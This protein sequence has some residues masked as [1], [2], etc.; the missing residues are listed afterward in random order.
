MAFRMQIKRLAMFLSCMLAMPSLSSPVGRQA[1]LSQRLRGVVEVSKEGVRL[2]AL[3]NIGDAPDDV[4]WLGPSKLVLAGVAG[5][6]ELNERLSQ[7]ILRLRSSRETRHV[8]NRG[9]WQSAKDLHRQGFSELVDLKGK[10]EPLALA[11]F[12]RGTVT[13]PQDAQGPP[14]FVIADLWANVLGPG[15]SNVWHSHCKSEQCRSGRSGSSPGISGVYYVSVGN[16]GPAQLQLRDDDGFGNTSLIEV[17]PQPGQ[18]VL[19]PAWMQHAV[20][21]VESGPRI[22]IA[23]N[24]VPRW[25]SSHAQRAAFLGESASVSQ[26]VQGS[27]DANEQNSRGLSLLHRAAEAGHVA[28]A[29][30]LLEQK[31]KVSVA[32]QDDR[33]P[34]HWAAEGGHLQ[35]VQLLVDEGANVNAQGVGGQPIHIASKLG[36]LRLVQFLLGARAEVRAG[37]G[38]DRAEPLHLASASGAAAVVQ[39]LLNSSEGIGGLRAATGKGWLPLHYAAFQGN[40]DVTQILLAAR[41]DPAAPVTGRRGGGNLA[42][43]LAAQRGSVPTLEALVA[44]PSPE[45]MAAVSWQCARGAD[46]QLVLEAG[47]KHGHEQVVQW[48]AQ[49]AGSNC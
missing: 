33:Q 42:I 47:K 18:L 3:E 6:T 29:K 37:G 35:L 1:R 15:N 32:A 8:S 34:I 30:I 7:L 31:A 25:F 36:N 10:L 45:N 24:L 39:T 44:A 41:A 19:F 14:T 21:H 46:S 40:A 43:H 49:M 5:D 16:S 26:L 23:F 2:G 11:H 22:S 20:P 48:F 13:A 38:D 27:D 9:G 4:E 17:E 28:V 12:A